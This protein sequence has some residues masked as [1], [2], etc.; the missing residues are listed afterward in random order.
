VERSLR[1]TFD[2]RA[3]IQQRDTD[4]VSPCLDR[5]PHF[6]PMVGTDQ[7]GAEGAVVPADGTARKSLALAFPARRP[8]LARRIL[9]LRRLASDAHSTCRRVRVAVMSIIVPLFLIG[10]SALQAAPPP[11]GSGQRIT[12][13]VER[14]DYD[15]RRLVAPSPLTENELAGRRLYVQRCG[16]CHDSTLTATPGPWLDQ[17]TIKRRGEAAREVI[18]T[19][20]PR[21]PGFQYTLQAAQIDQIIAFLRTVT[22]DQKPGAAT[23][24][25]ESVSDR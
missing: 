12:P 15:M 1:R 8:I 6:E 7:I 16:I 4:L 21:M 23:S 9:A 17:E 19:G 10:L 3:L 24:P 11:P 5:Q 14:K 22:P 18:L 25:R 20:S 13:K 2:F